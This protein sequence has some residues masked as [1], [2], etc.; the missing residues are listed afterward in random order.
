MFYL[1]LPLI[2]PS[3]STSHFELVLTAVKMPFVVRLQNTSLTSDKAIEN[4]YNN[5][6]QESVLNDEMYHQIF[7]HFTQFGC[8]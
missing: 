6:M 1:L 3:F 8:R 4:D 5:D 2:Y 7:T